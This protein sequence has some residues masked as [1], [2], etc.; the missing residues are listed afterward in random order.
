M[1]KKKD[2]IN[3]YLSNYFYVYIYI[4]CIKLLHTILLFSYFY[5]LTF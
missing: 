3:L 4:L 5:F 1:N 2:T